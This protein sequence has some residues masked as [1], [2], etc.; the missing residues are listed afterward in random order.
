M[1]TDA[2][3][4]PSAIIPAHHRAALL[5]ETIDA[6]L[7]QSLPPYEVIV[8]DDGSSD[9]TAEVIQS[10]S[11]RV[12]M[13]RG[14]GRGAPYARKLGSSMAMGTWLVFCDDD[15]LWQPDHLAAI[16]ELSLREPAIR[17]T[18]RISSS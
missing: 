11:G 3:F 17:F 18:S 14:V 16:R 10:Y 9:N 8:V 1:G 12:L 15:D 5:K 6:V 4:P 7:A 2:H 13:C